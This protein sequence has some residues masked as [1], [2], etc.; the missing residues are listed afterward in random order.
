LQENAKGV[1]IATLSRVFKYY[2]IRIRGIM[3]GLRVIALID[4]GGTH[5]F[6][7]SIFVTMR[8]ILV[9][10]FEGFNVVVADGYNMT[11]T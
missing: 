11:C 2:T 4:G 7:D 3:Q 8:H 10:E 9:E 5:N 6:I 1:T